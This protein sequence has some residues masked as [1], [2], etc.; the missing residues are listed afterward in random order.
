MI[1]VIEK[2]YTGMQDKLTLNSVIVKVFPYVLDK[3]GS[4][5]D[6]TY[7]ERQVA[8]NL[9]LK[10][11]NLTRSSYSDIATKYG[12]TRGAVLKRRRA[13]LKKEVIIDG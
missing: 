3:F 13:L 10:H 7:T 6:I 5:I 2:S 11:R 4:Y 1:K 12:V 9:E 8:L